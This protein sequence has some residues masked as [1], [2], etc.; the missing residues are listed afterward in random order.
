MNILVA[1]LGSTSFK[2][3]LFRFDGDTAVAVAK[4]GYERVTDYGRAI[5]DSLA[6]L[7]AEGKLASA[8]DLDAVAF[9]TVLGGALTGCLDADER[10]EAALLATADLAPAHN[11]PYAAGIRQFRE[12]FPGVR[13]IALF[14][15]AFYQWLPEA[16]H[17]YAV[18]EA[19]YQAGVRR[20]GFHG[21]SHKFAAERA[22][23]LAGREDVAA[24]VRELYQAG[25]RPLGT[26]FRHINCHLGGSSSVTGVR[27][28]V[29][30]G[31]SMGLSP[32][33]GLPQNNRVGDLDSAAIPFIH[34]KL[35]LSIPEIERQLTK[36]SGL[37][38]LSG[39]G[40]DMRDIRAAAA[41]GDTRAAMTV[42]AFARSIRHWVGAFWLELGGCDVLSFTGGIGENDHA[43]RAA[44]CAGLEGLGLTLD[45]ALNNASPAE[46][47]LARP[48]STTRVL[49]I[50]ANEELV[51]AREARRHLLAGRS[52]A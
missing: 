22:A 13:R 23:E 12:K 40:N 8:T 31:T 6:A 30:L 24:V 19:W 21:A 36:E 38:G 26:P 15:T 52:A 5:D 17:R 18:P 7:A 9:K 25:P 45:P 35:G 1:N 42:E 44:I 46:T 27:D 2:Y 4:G 11:P 37:L 48:G 16:A 20:Y 50:P 43:L 39:V 41:Q 49:A 28:G 29:A 10:V 47:N 51:I 34:R 14:E 3:R 32:Q 33:S